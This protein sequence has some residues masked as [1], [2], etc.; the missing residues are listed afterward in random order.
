MSLEALLKS[1]PDTSTQKVEANNRSLIKA[2]PKCMTFI[3]TYH[4]RAMGHVLKI[5]M[6]ATEAQTAIQKKFGHNITQVCTDKLKTIEL[7]SQKRKKWAQLP[8]NK[9]KKEL[10]SVKLYSVYMKKLKA[11]QLSTEKR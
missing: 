8:K 10:R 4:T 5:N 9:K 1:N 2:I 3:R 6:G 11:G 7:K